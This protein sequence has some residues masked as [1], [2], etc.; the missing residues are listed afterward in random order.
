VNDRTDDDRMRRLLEDAVS[1]VTPRGR[2]EDIRAR[3]ARARHGRRG[4]LWGAG[5]GVVATAATVAAVVTLT[6]GPGTPG[7]AQGGF[8]SNASGSHAASPGAQHAS[9][10]PPAATPQGTPTVVRSA[11]SQPTPS[12]GTPVSTLTVPV[13]FV[14]DT[15]HGPRLYKDN[16]LAPASDPVRTAVHAAVAGNTLDPDYHSPWPAG[17]DVTGVTADSSGI[18]VA[19]K[20]G[21]TSLTARPAGMSRQTAR[22]AVQQV[23]HTA[24]DAVGSQAPVNFTVAGKPASRLLGLDVSGGVKRAADLDVEAVVWVLSPAQGATV[25]SPFTVTGLANTFEAN[26]VWELERNGH[27]VK[28]GHTTAT[29]AMMMAPYSFTVHAPPGQYLLVVHDSD[30]SGLGKVTEDTKAITVR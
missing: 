13:Y 11:A 3:T 5:A 14:G 17:T 30:A 22:I 15:P 23:V 8:A 7:S 27:V 25:H 4:W 16:Q 18:T 29:Q 2:L 9:G 6:Q 26:V 21:D 10:Q 19:L 12:K 1:D 24:Q 28:Q 20:S